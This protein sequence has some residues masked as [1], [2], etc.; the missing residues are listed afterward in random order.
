MNPDP[1]LEEDDYVVNYYMDVPC[2]PDRFSDERYDGLPAFE[3]EEDPVLATRL[4]GAD[5][6]CE[7]E[8]S[9][10][11]FAVNDAACQRRTIEFYAMTLED[12]RAEARGWGG[13]VAWRPKDA[14]RSAREQLLH[15]LSRHGE[16]RTYWGTTKRN[17]KRSKKTTDTPRSA[18]SPQPAAAAEPPAPSRPVRL[19]PLH[20]PRPR[21][22]PQ[23]RLWRR[24]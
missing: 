13:N 9:S 23:P 19:R 12:T 4:W 7:A 24:R 6:W 15:E 8:G 2:R 16:S 3:P 14:R 10:E 21:P 11:L 20:L 5:K 1:D 22:R 17:R 18:P